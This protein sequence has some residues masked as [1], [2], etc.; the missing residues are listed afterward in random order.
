[1][2]ARAFVKVFVAP[3]IF[4]NAVKVRALPVRGAGGLFDQGLQSVPAGWVEAIIDLKRV[5]GCLESGDLSHCR[6]H[7]RTMT[8]TSWAE[9]QHD[10]DE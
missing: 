5:Q 8:G 3:G 9:G 2:P 7:V 10:P 6:R 1:M 4:G